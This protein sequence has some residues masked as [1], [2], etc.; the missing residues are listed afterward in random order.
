MGSGDA[1]PEVLCETLRVRVDS[2]LLFVAMWRRASRGRAGPVQQRGAAAAATP[3]AGANRSDRLLG[4]GRHAR[5]AMAHGH[6][7]QRRLRERSDHARGE[8]GRR[9]LGPREGRSG[10]RAMC[11][12]MALPRS[13]LFLPVCAS[14]GKTRTR[15]KVET[16]AGMQTRLLHFG[17]WKPQGGPASWQGESVAEWERGR[18]GRGAAPMGGS[19][20]S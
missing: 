20:E 4:L 8:E 15:F 17:D 2:P 1:G 18:G 10:G 5:L 19:L 13:W 12:P 6:A 3:R 14:R 16:D 9:R 11:K 7:G